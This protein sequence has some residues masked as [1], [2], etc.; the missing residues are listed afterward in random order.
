MV[1]AMAMAMA[2]PMS[3]PNSIATRLTSRPFGYP[4]AP[5]SGRLMRGR[6]E[7]V[8]DRGSLGRPVALVFGGFGQATAAREA[9]FERRVLG[10]LLR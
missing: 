4:I 5:V 6:G 7:L 8:A 9:G 2:R 1:M 10:E 3:T